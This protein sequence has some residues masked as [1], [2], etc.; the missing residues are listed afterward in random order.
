MSGPQQTAFDDLPLFSAA[1]ADEARRTTRRTHPE[2]SLAASANSI[3]SGNRAKHEAAA[4][5]LVRKYPGNT[6]AELDRI[7]GSENREIGKRL[8]GLANR[9]L[10]RRGD[11]RVC[12][13]RG[14]KCVTWYVGAACDD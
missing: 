13:V 3:A 8:G 12:E 2:T 4:L 14:R 10:L 1:I 6:A 5:R 11:R 9:G 7:A